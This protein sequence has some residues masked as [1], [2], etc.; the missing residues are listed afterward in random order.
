MSKSPRKPLGTGSTPKL[1]PPL[2]YF[3]LMDRLYIPHEER[4]MAER[5]GAEYEAY[6]ARVRR[7]V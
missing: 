3:L 6:R 2:G 5:F 7:W 4:R 1:L